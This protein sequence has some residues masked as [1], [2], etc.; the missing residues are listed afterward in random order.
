MIDNLLK[1]QAFLDL[2]DHVTLDRL[3]YWRESL[4]EEREKL[5]MIE[6]KPHQKEDWV[7]LV[8]DI[9]AIDRVI[10]FFEGRG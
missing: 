7:E 3:K 5:D 9:R 4:V 1:S 8:Q 6:R 2:C 10:A